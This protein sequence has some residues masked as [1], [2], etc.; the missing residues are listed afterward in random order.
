MLAQLHSWKEENER[1]SLKKDF[2]KKNFKD[3]PWATNFIISRKGDILLGLD[4]I[5]KIVPPRCS[6]ILFSS[7]CFKKQE[8]DKSPSLGLG[9]HSPESPGVP[10]ALPYIIDER[11]K[12]CRLSMTFPFGLRCLL[13]PLLLS[14][15]EQLQTLN[16]QGEQRAGRA[17]RSAEKT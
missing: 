3:F 6:K 11:Q 15:Q 12:L 7:L 14:E 9:C 16:H 13:L 1:A 17:G 10:A 8:R 4:T 2:S 5:R